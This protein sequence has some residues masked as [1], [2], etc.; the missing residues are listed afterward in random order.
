MPKR[1]FQ[2]FFPLLFAFLLL[3]TFSPQPA[4]AQA[5][6]PTPGGATP[7]GPGTVIPEIPTASPILITYPLHGIKVT[8]VINILGS[9][10]LEG[11]TS[12]E[13]AFAYANDQSNSWF[14]FG[15]GANP[16]TGGSTLASWDT[17]TVS[18]GDYNIRL[19]VFSP[20]GSQ[21][22]FIYGLRV[23]NYTADTPVPTLTFTP[24][25]TS[26]DTPLPTFTP[27]QTLTP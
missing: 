17:T 25:P 21:D 10:T 4:S 23:R 7:A 14:T 1:G 5:A 22:G 8:G 27:T 12:Y 15:G 13:V 9:I 6:S 20:G 3:W 26:A 2:V 18:D 11:W 19:R 24:T 16:S